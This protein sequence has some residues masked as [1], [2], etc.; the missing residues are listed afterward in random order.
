MKMVIEVH[1]SA[2]C[3][4]VYVTLTSASVSGAGEPIENV[5]IFSCRLAEGGPLCSSLFSD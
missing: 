4:L 2:L 3:W 5:S 1:G